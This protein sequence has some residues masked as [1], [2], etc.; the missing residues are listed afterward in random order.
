MG[1][2]EPSSGGMRPTPERQIDVEDATFVGPA[3]RH[4]SKAERAAR[5][6]G[7][8]G[9]QG[10]FRGEQLTFLE[11]SVDTYLAL[12]QEKGGARNT[13]LAKFWVAV[14]FGF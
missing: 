4:R 8:A 11:E 1:G 13:A 10:R 6:G 12:P 3:K 7:K 9:N 14:M 2:I 5:K